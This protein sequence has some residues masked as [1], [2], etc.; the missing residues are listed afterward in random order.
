MGCLA[1]PPTPQENGKRE[2]LTLLSPYTPPPGAGQ[3]EL[4]LGQ[5][6]AHPP[7]QQDAKGAGT[8][9]R[10]ILMRR[11]LVIY[12]FKYQKNILSFLEVFFT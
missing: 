4:F 11:L 10:Y 6:Q 1:S 9:N 8:Q 2:E 7:P 3:G 5:A 12:F